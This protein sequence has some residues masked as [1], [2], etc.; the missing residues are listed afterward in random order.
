MIPKV[1]HYCWFGKGPLPSSARK[2]IDSW[3][4]YFP[5]YEI[6]QWNE[7]NFEIDKFDYTKEA[8]AAKKYAFVSDFVRFWVLYHHGGLY[9]DTDVE[10][11]KDFSDILNCGPFMGFELNP[12]NKMN[13]MMRIN[14]GLGIGAT[15]F[16]PFY[17]ELLDLYAS[18]HWVSYTESQGVM[19]T[20][21]DYTTDLFIKKGIKVLN[22]IQRIDGINIYPENYFCP[23]S[24]NS[25]KLT[26]Y[27]ETHS[28]HWFDQSW[29]S[30]IRKYGRK[31]LINVCGTKFKNLIKNILRLK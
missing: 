24:I 17:K 30:T 31:I 16:H 19:P 22:G 21:V 8:Y 2:C 29:Q 25:G 23:I 12:I 10:V 1:I 26:M 13:K 11:V 6:K 20:V 14:P 27:P 7:D 9:F 28:I 4:K 18:M 3:I 15:P 5:D